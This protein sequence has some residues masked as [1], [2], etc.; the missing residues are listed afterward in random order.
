M[1][2]SATKEHH[3]LLSEHF[4]ITAIPGQ[5]TVALAG[6]PNVG[7]STVF[8]ALT[9][10]HQHTGNW[11]GKTVDNAQGSF[12]YLDRSFLMV[13]LPGTYSILAHTIEEQ[14][15]RD[16]I[17]FGKPDVTLV[18]LDAT[19]LERNLNLALQVMEI[20]P[21]IIVCVNLMDEAEKKN[22]K[23]DLSALQ[24]DLGVPVVAT[25][26]RS[27]MGLDTLRQ[28][29]HEM[30]I[31]LCTPTPRQ[32]SYSSEVENAIQQLLPNVSRLIGS[33]LN[34]RWVTLR[35]LDGDQAFI[36]SISQY[37]NLDLHSTRLQ[38]VAV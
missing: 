15:A 3:K 25:A 30:S 31:G 32:I 24:K 17:C 22:I 10:L 6:N 2:H 12:T 26:A 33:N 29:L 16:F 34:P 5:F 11:P 14:V 38:E 20:T 1:N 23:I 36:K 18:V 35:L 28:K 21:K 8:N 19:C 4:G 13:D 37:L 9:G 7:K 27:G